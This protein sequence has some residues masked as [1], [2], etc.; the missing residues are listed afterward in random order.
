MAGSP[1]G[2]QLLERVKCIGDDDERRTLAGG[3]LDR[4]FDQRGHGAGAQRIGDEGVP[5][6]ALATERNVDRAGGHAA[7]VDRCTSHLD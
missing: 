2:G 3:Q 5:V 7:G 4:A 1:P 6:H